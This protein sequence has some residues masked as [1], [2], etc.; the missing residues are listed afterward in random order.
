M[1]LA[2]IKRGRVLA[3]DSQGFWL[4][5][6]APMEWIFW[7]YSSGYGPQSD[8]LAGP[9]LVDTLNVDHWEALV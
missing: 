8:I 4:Q 2:G 1:A 5:G 6:C 9:I 3:T 7:Y